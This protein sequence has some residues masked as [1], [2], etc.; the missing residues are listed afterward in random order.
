MNLNLFPSHIKNKILKGK[1]L[2]HTKL[3]TIECPQLFKFQYE[4]KLEQPFVEIMAA[5]NY[6]DSLCNGEH[7]QP[8][9]RIPDERVVSILRRYELYKDHIL[10]ED[11]LQVPL[12]REIPDTE[13]VLIG[14]ADRVRDSITGLFDH[15]LAEVPWT[16][17]KYKAAQMQ[18]RLYFWMAEG[19]SLHL[20]K[21]FFHVVNMENEDIQE[22]GP[23]KPTAK[24]CLLYQP[25]FKKQSRRFNLLTASPSYHS[26]VNGRPRMDAR[27]SVGI[28]IYAH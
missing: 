16:D 4:D 18:L 22:F 25:Y 6:Y 17:S 12:W 14:W 8:D 26:D 20:D 5:G 1:S 19:M 13:Y 2:S 27:V 24:G 23:Y 28:T 10:P 7:L 21:G 11:R 9:G 3:K 15:K